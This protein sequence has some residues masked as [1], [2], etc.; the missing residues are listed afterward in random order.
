MSWVDE[1]AP[2]PVV[3]GVDAAGAGIVREP[4][5]RLSA[6]E[7][8]RSGAASRMTAVTAAAVA[9]ARSL[10]AHRSDELTGSERVQAAVV[11]DRGGES[12]PDAPVGFGR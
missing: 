1:A 4:V 2:S 11:A 3:F 12:A 6:R 7:A 8:L 10:P 5:V 9:V